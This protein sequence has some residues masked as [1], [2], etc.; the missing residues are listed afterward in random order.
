MCGR[1]FSRI[2]RERRERRDALEEEEKSLEY[3]VYGK[4]EFD[5]GNGKKSKAE[6]GRRWCP[7]NE[8]SEVEDWEDY[9]KAYEIQLRAAREEAQETYG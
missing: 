2:P 6:W 1:R 5:R 7:V 4:F 9:L 3:D 8:C